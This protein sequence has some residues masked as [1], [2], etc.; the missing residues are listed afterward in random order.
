MQNVSIDKDRNTAHMDLGNH[1]QAIKMIKLLSK[2][3]IRA[4]LITGNNTATT[5]MY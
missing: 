3:D 5:S 4:I 2:D 1:L